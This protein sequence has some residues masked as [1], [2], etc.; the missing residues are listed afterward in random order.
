MTQQDG[1]TRLQTLGPEDDDDVTGHAAMI[2]N[3]DLGG[4][5]RSQ[6]RDRYRDADEVKQAKASQDEREGT[7]R[8]LLGR[9][10]GR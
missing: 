8:S 10:F 6:D 1:T 9:L 5:A 4:L 7:H 2:G 3:A